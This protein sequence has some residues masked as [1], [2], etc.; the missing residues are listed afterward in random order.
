[1]ILHLGVIDVP[2]V[3]EGNLQTTGNV[4]QW[5]ENR[6]GIMG[7]FAVQHGEDIADAMANSI[8]GA[9][10]SLMMGAPPNGN[11]FAESMGQIEDFF[12]ASLDAKE[13]DGLP[14]VPTKRSLDRASLR[15]KSKKNPKERPSFIDTGLYQASFRA[16]IDE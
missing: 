14:G 6:Y 9:L 10:E 13:Y 2:Y 4:A 1:M 5:L 8:A 16:W 3:D 12:R 15:F 7:F 11:P